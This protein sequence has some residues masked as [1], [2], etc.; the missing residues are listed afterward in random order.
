MPLRSLKMKRFI[1]GFHRR[2]WCPKCTP[3][4]SSCFMVTTAM[5]RA[6]S[7]ELSQPGLAWTGG[8]ARPRLSR[9]P[10]G[11]RP[12]VR[13]RDRAVLSGLAGG[14]EVGR[15]LPA[16]GRRTREVDPPERDALAVYGGRDRRGP[17]PPRGGRGPRGGPPPVLRRFAPPASPYGPGHRGVDLGGAP[18]DPVLAA[19]P[20]VVVHAGVL[21]GRGV[22]SVQHPSGLR[23]TYEPLAVTVRKG[24]AVSRG[25]L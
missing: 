3:L 21:A 25:A 22:V 9:R 13:C 10:G 19:G 14:T 2:V 24:A 6:S 1:F 8:P 17:P 11:R 16:R 7:A 5:R 20:G 15:H 4:S 12:G 23:T 18:G